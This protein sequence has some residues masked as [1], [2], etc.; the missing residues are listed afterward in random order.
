MLIGWIWFLEYQDLIDVPIQLQVVCAPQTTGKGFRGSG[1]GSL[2][3]LN[4]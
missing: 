4:P 3:T 2:L 1:S